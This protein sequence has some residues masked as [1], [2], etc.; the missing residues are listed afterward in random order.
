MILKKYIC[1]TFFHSK[2]GFDGLFFARLDYQDEDQRNKTK[3]MEL[4]WKGS[5]DLGEFSWQ[6][7]RSSIYTYIHTY[8]QIVKA[9]YLRAFYGIFTTRQT[10]FVSIGLA[11]ISP[12]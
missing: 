10:R 8:L 12:L 4:I 9:G 3:T 11:A 2:M 1:Y 7:P 6:Y 5:A